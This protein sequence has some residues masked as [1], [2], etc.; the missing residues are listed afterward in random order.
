MNTCNSKREVNRAIQ[1][2]GYEV[3]KVP[4]Q[5]DKREILVATKPK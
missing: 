4:G 3:I 2:F 5:Y 1:A